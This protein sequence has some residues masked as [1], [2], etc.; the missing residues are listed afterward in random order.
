M[1]KTKILSAA[2]IRGVDD[3]KKEL[4]EVPEWGGSV[5]VR[6]MTAKERDDFDASLRAEAETSPA[7]NK[8]E[9]DNLRARLA[10]A[11]CCDEAGKLLF[12]L[13]D[14]EL[15]G[16]KSASALNRLFQVALRLNPSGNAA[17]EDAKKN[18]TE[19]G[20]GDSA[21]DSPSPSA[22]GT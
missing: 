8:G 19:T 2:D 16:Q 12:T 7:G 14:V 5:Y 3:S 22:S 20:S 17:V 18:S 11:T 15:L 6:N 1:S 10:A 13:A 4:V 21:S 9:G